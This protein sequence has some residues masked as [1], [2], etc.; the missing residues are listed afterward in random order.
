MTITQQQMER[1]I[2]L[3]IGKP[4]A[5]ALYGSGLALVLVFLAALRGLR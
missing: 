2:Q 5:W 3:L 1:L 4:L